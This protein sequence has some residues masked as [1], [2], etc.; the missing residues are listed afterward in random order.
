MKPG[1][2][3]MIAGEMYHQTPELLEVRFKT[4]DLLYEYKS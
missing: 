2:E 4:R 3:K 1:L